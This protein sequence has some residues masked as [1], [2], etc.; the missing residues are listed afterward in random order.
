MLTIENNLIFAVRN[1]LYKIDVVNEKCDEVEVAPVNESSIITNIC[2]KNDLIGLCTND[3]QL[4]LFSNELKIIHQWVT[5]RAPSD[6]T[7]LNENEII[8]ADKTGDVYLYKQNELKPKLILG[9]LSMVLSV[10]F[11]NNYI[12]T[13]DRDEKIRVTSYPE[14]YNI[15]SYCLGHEEFV[16]KLKLINDQTIL[17]IGGDGTF[18]IW[19]YINGKELL[20]VDCMKYA[21][22]DVQG[23]F[24]NKMEQLSV[25]VKSLPITSVDILKGTDLVV[26]VS[27]YESNQILLFQI[28]KDYVCK[29]LRIVEVE[30]QII[31]FSFCNEYLFVLLINKLVCYNLNGE[32]VIKKFI[33]DMKFEGSLVDTIPLLYKRSFDNLQ[34]YHERKRMKIDK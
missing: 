22:D 25:K 32:K 4:I 27:L 23:E 18:R 2:H 15:Q 17:S 13:T 3:K 6:L 20:C 10:E 1:K 19:D 28:E 11:N 9:H 21:K 29:F 5:Q 7:I 12:I 26:A 30:D 8:L 14:T 16:T 33:D 31:S 24:V 34:D